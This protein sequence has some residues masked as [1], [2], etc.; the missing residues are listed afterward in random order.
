[1]K[2]IKSGVGILFS[3]VV[4]TMMVAC[5]NDSAGVE[6]NQSAGASN[7][8]LTELDIY[9]SES[10]GCCGAWIEHM[11]D[12]NFSARI[13]HPTDLND[14]K[15]RYGIDAQWQSCH[16]AV[17][18]EGY[19]FEGHIPAKFIQQFLTRPPADAIGL[20]VPGMPLG[21]PGMEVN[22]RFMPYQIILLKKDGSTETY[23]TV[24]SLQQQY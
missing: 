23:A 16:T 21:S 2:F 17:S 11:E 12:N 10:C 24:N 9:K 18:K 1:M 3:L 8:T 13:H 7:L 6:T 5:G 14:I 4:F 20:A 22:D 15:T 19:V